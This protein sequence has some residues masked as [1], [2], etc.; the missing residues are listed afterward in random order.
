MAQARRDF[1]RG[2]LKSVRLVSATDATWSVQITST[3]AVDGTGWLLG[4][5][6]K[7]VRRIKSLDSAAEAVR[8][9]GFSVQQLTIA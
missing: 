5:K 6:T 8:Q 4:A 7:E 3:L 1:E 9:I 2:L